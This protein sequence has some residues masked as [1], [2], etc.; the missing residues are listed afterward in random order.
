MVDVI[1]QAA[2]ALGVLAVG[3][4]AAYGGLSFAWT[5]L[6]AWR[7]YF[8]SRRWSAAAGRITR[9]GIVPIRSHRSIRYQPEVVYTF[10]ADGQ[11]HTGQRL[12]FASWTQWLAQAEAERALAPYPPGA[13]V[14]VLYD[15]QRP[16]DS[17]LERR[18][19]G[20]VS[21]SCGVVL[22]LTGASLLCLLTALIGLRAGP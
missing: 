12:T 10:T 15:P 17:V 20:G 1:F 21:V 16:Q 18:A 4:L 8:A 2:A 22:L 7:G 3:L 6:K 13:A 5:D 19:P 11:T 14:T 9:A